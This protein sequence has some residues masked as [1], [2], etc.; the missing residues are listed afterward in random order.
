MKYLFYLSFAILIFSSCGKSF[1]QIFE[2]VA[3][4]VETKNDYY[5]F[6][7]D[8]LRI[9]YSFWTSQ[10]VMSFSVYN[11]SDRPIYID[12]KNSSF[13]YNGKKLN[14]WIDEFQSNSQSSEISRTNKSS[15]IS[16][17]YNGYYYIGTPIIWGS[18]NNQSYISSNSLSTTQTETHSSTFK[19]ERVTF[20]PPKSTF[21]CSR[22]YLLP[23]DYFK[24]N[25]K[26]I[27]KLI[28]PR[29][30]NPINMTKVYEE[31]FDF[32]SSPLVFRNY[33]A[34]SFSENSTNYFF[35]DNEFYLSSVKEMDYRHY[36][37]RNVGK[38][39]NGR[40]IYEKPFKKPQNFYINIDGVNTV[41]YRSGM[42]FK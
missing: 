31:K 33:L 10:G 7:S 15:T 22:F 18:S 39:E 1:I 12:W 23:I 24:L 29:N 36:R 37:G 30:D 16:S 26:T 17:Y 19:P 27:S 13:I 21:S 3:N 5:V 8:T 42:Y 6:E 14:Y 40:A 9:T 4:N 38:D 41:E 28:V 11:K 34:F 25:T 2:T 32:L 35:I 20:I